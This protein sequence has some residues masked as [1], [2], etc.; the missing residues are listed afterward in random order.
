MWSAADDFISCPGQRMSVHFLPG[1]LA[2][3]VFREKHLTS[4]SSASPRT[5]CLKYQPFPNCSALAQPSV[6]CGAQQPSAPLEDLRALGSEQQACPGG[7]GGPAPL[8][9]PSGL[10]ATCRESPRGSEP[11]GV[12]EPPL[13]LMSGLKGTLAGHPP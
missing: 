2:L 10:R 13:V 7:A 1:V 11:A 12:A 5:T 3:V 8:S 4:A 9:G 6:G